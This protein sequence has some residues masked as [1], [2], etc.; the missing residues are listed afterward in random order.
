MRTW[1]AIVLTAFAVGIAP[2]EALGASS[3]DMSATHTALVAAYKSLREVVDTWPKVEASFR[4]LDRKFA[5]ECPSVGMG[6]PQNEPEQRLSY[7]IAGA[8]WA[9][10]Y[11]TDAGIARAF[12][13]AVEPL[14]WSNPSLTRR[15]HQ[16]ITGL[17]EMTA[18]QVP[19]LCADI[20]S[21]AASGYRTVPASTLTFDQHV[22]AIDVEVPSPRILAQYVRPSDRPLL[23][24]V[25]RLV[26]RFE[27]L[28][29]MT[30]QREWIKLLGVVGLNE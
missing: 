8:L 24:R 19:D 1:L 29:F 18:L 5:A 4:V 28:E 27:E 10:G 22:E 7:E 12:I 2:G 9:T 11:R 3:R 26:T 23:A 21:W 30:G 25:E 15:A 20:R 13:K 17:R 14:R 6:S 16:Y